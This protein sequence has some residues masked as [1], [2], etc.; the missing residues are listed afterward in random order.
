MA[1]D[2]RGALVDNGDPFS[3]LF[4]SEPNRTQTELADRRQAHAV[5]SARLIDGF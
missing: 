4:A 3:T 1:R 2:R 5:L